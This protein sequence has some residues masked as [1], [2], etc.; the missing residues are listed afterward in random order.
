[1]SGEFRYGSRARGTNPRAKRTN[2]RR[3]GTNPSA[4]TPAD[5][6]RVDRLKRRALARLH[7]RGEVWCITC[8]DDMVTDPNA[9]GR[10]S[11]CHAHTDLTA[12]DAADILE[13]FI[14]GHL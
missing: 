5:I 11:P 9:T 10:W 7:A 3:A 1:M 14:G 13:G 4:G 6:A 2:P 12:N 8:R